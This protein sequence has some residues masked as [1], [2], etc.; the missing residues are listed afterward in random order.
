MSHPQFG[1]LIGLVLGVVWAFAGL[2]GA[3]LTGV[4][5]GLGAL[6]GAIVA[7]RVD[8]TDYLGHEHDSRTGRTS[9]R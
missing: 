9:S 3:L 5:A 4:L 2:D 7:G 6:A 1:C 8:L